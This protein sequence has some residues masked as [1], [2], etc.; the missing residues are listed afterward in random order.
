MTTLWSLIDG[1][2]RGGGGGVEKYGGW[3][4]FTNI[5]SRGE[6]IFQNFKR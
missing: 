6:W 4:I 2:G 5:N 3:K 1:G